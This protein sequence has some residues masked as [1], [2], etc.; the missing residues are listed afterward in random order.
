MLVSPNNH[1]WCQIEP[2]VIQDHLQGYLQTADDW[3]KGQNIKP[4]VNF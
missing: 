2:A 4:P 3:K 1:F